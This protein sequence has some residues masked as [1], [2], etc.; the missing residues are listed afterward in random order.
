MKKKV[1]KH[2][3]PAISQA[4]HDMHEAVKYDTNSFNPDHLKQIEAW[5]HLFTSNE[6][7]DVRCIK[8]LV[9]VSIVAVDGGSAA[10]SSTDCPPGVGS[11]SIFSELAS[12]S[13]ALALAA[14]A[15]SF[16][17]IMPTIPDA[18]DANK[19][20]AKRRKGVVGSSDGKK[21]SKK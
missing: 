11:A 19:P 18:D 1:E 13:S 16:D 20:P 9:K 3:L 12:A 10:A 6:H 8:D 4:L 14:H 7:E 5:R 15:N 2:G 17:D 21:V